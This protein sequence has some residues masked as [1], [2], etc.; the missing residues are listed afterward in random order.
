MTTIG[1]S[2]AQPPGHHLKAWRKHRGLNQEQLAER[3]RELLPQTED[4]PNEG[5]FERTRI[6]KFERG[7]EGMREKV[8]YALA[9]ALDIEVGWL[10]VHPDIIMRERAILRAV[11]NR[12]PEDLATLFETLKRVS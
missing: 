7:V 3:V 10:F 1:L 11:G 12:S 6:S 4:E 8:I 2:G 9:A 5:S